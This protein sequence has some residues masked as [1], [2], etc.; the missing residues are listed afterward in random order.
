MEGLE[1]LPKL[2]ATIQETLRLNPNG[3]LIPRATA[4]ATKVRN[5]VVP[6]N[7]QVWVNAYH[8]NYDPVTFP[9]PTSFSPQ[10]WLRPDG[11]FRREDPYTK[12]H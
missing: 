7:C 1:K 5:Y 8:I 12:Y 6:A 10:R 9:D 11:T 4:H 3:P 2:E